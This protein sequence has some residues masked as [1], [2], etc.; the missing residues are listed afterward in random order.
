MSVLMAAL[1]CLSLLCLQQLPTSQALPLPSAQRN[2]QLKTREPPDRT[3]MDGNP[4]RRLMIY[5][6]SNAWAA[7]EKRME[8]KAVHEPQLAK[9]QPQTHSHFRGKRHSYSMRLSCGLGTCQVQNLSSRLWQLRQAGRD[10][11]SRISV[12]SPKSYG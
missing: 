4:Q 11:S 8:K 12:S 7:V 5:L 3:L 2:L 1:G 6:F 10:D 9:Q